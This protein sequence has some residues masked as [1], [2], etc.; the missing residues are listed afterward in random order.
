MRVCVYVRIFKS[1][2]RCPVRLFA[3]MIGS[4][5]A[6]YVFEQDNIAENH[7]KRASTLVCT[8]KAFR[9]A[10]C[11]ICKT[12]CLSPHDFNI[13]AWN[14]TH[15]PSCTHQKLNISPK[16]DSRFLFHFPEV[17]G[18]LEWVFD[19]MLEIRSVVNTSARYLHVLFYNIYKIPQ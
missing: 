2:Y 8:L 9:Y 7:R 10:F 16:N 5:L 3:L 15:K 6:F 12:H 19:W 11:A 13:T 1:T 17:S 14:N 4:I 18:F